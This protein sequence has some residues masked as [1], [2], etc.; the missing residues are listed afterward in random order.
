M[1]LVLSYISVFD[2]F[3]L[4]TSLH[5][6]TL[7]FPSHPHFMRFNLVWHSLKTPGRCS[8]TLLK[9]DDIFHC[10]IFSARHLDWRATSCGWPPA[11]TDASV[12]GLLTG[13]KTSVICWTGWLFLLPP[14]LGYC[15]I[16]FR[17]RNLL[18]SKNLMTGTFRSLIF[19]TFFLFNVVRWVVINC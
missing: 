6:Q 3:F 19:V 8:M 13:W 14:F 2:S 18:V 12:C 10:S 7:T 15:F 9:P 11:P 1:A 5:E 4:K 17:Y 16:F